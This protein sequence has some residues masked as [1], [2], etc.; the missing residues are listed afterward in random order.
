MY[1]YMMKYRVHSI[2]NAYLRECLKRE[3]VPKGLRVVKYPNNVVV[4]SHFHKSLVKIFNNCGLEILKAI[5]EENE[6]KQ[7]E[8][9][10]EIEELDKNIKTDLIFNIKEERDRFYNIR[11]DIDTKCEN[12]TQRKMGKL[13]RDINKYENDI[14]YPKPIEKGYNT[15]GFRRKSNNFFKKQGGY[16]N[17]SDVEWETEVYNNE[18]P[19]LGGKKVYEPADKGGAVVVHN[20]VDY[21]AEAERQ[22]SN[23]LHYMAM[24]TDPTSTPKPEVSTKQDEAIKK[25][26]A[27]AKST[28]CD[29]NEI[30]IILSFFCFLLLALSTAVIIFYVQEKGKNVD[31]HMKKLKLESNL[32]VVSQK[33]SQLRDAFCTSSNGTM[34]TVFPWGKLNVSG[35]T[36]YFQDSIYF[37]SNKKLSWNDSMKACMSMISNLV[38]INDEEEKNFIKESTVITRAPYWIGLTDQK[39]E[40]KWCWV[41]DPDCN[42]THTKYW[43]NGEPN[44]SNNEDCATE[45]FKKNTQLTWNDDGCHKPHRW[46]CERSA[47]FIFV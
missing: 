39:V 40:G 6:N 35:W 14:S 8:L 37:F 7:N 15:N 11:R 27:L 36:T 12:I 38:V 47:S 31:Y 16:V 22:L 32:S 28:L 18:F 46:I 25:E 44:D 30:F 26:N 2:E 5:I 10:K 23:K 13:K 41:D 9:V 29:R 20:W 17:R 21:E 1:N 3:V 34:C 24:P 42:V 45:Q 33:F 4:G 19:P 43:G